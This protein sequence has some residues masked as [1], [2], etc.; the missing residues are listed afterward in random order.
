[1]FTCDKRPTGS[2]RAIESSA[3]GWGCRMHTPV[4][5]FEGSDAYD[6]DLED[7]H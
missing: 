1:M 5:R 4:Y 3:I 2:K 6:C 7:Y